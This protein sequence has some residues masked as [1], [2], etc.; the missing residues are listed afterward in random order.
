M[1][2]TPFSQ[3]AQLAAPLA[4]SAAPTA[5]SSSWQQQQQL[6]AVLEEQLTEVEAIEVAVDEAMLQ[7]G[8]LSA[9]AR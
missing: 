7:W 8:T 2:D 9:I 3:G 6:A 1:F 4:T 5:S